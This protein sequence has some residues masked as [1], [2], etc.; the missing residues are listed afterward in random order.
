[1]DLR[2]SSEERGLTAF[3]AEALTFTGSLTLSAVTS[4]ASLA[5]AT[6]DT[7]ADTLGWSSRT[8]YRLQFL[9]SHDLLLC[10][11]PPILSV[12]IGDSANVDLLVLFSGDFPGGGAVGNFCYRY[13]MRNFVDHSSY[14]RAVG[15][16]YGA[17]V[18]AE[19]KRSDYFF[20][21]LFF[22]DKAFVQCDFQHLS[23]TLLLTAYSGVSL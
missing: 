12:E 8:F 9:E 11:A 6:G 13:Q 10:L 2:Q 20:L 16:H 22:A 15:M 21:G 1:V 18:F 4:I 5:G 17:T 3:E 19:T 7:T 14:C 23:F